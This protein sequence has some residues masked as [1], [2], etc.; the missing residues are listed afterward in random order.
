MNLGGGNFR[1]EEIE[2]RCFAWVCFDWYETESVYMIHV[3]IVST[4]MFRDFGMGVR[5]FVEVA[6]T[7]ETGLQ[8]FR[9][10]PAMWLNSVLST[11]LTFNAKGMK[12]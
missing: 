4:M 7:A 6:L 11:N 12:H 5:G 3:K 2:M 1:K 8:D 9:R 10:L